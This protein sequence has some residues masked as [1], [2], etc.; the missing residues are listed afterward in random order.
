MTLL[1]YQPAT[2]AAG[3]TIQ[4]AGKYQ[5]AVHVSANEKYVDGVF[6]Y[7]KC[8]LVF[9]V[10]GAILLE[11]EFVRQEGKS[12]HFDFEQDWQ[13]S[14]H[15]LQFEIKPLTPD[16]MQTRSLAVRI[17]AVTVRG[18]LGQEHWVRPKSHERF[19]PARSARG[20]LP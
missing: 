8:Q 12:Y 14:D 20:L 1:Y 15:S 19:F 13:A 18:P 9:K 10:D 16:E 2:V 17:I 4:H 3:L 7:N 5:L 11:R 6:D